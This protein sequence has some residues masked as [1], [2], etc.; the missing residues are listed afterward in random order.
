MK[1]VLLKLST[2]TWKKQLTSAGWRDLRPLMW[3]LLSGLLLQKNDAESLRKDSKC[4]IMI[5]SQQGWPELW[6]NRGLQNEILKC[7]LEAI[8]DSNMCRAI[9]QA[10]GKIL[11]KLCIY[12]S[13]VSL[14][15]FLLRF[16]IHFSYFIFSLFLSFFFLFF[17]TFV[18]SSYFYIYFY[19]FNLF[20]LLL[21][22]F[23][24]LL[25]FSFLSLHLTFNLDY[26]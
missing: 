10:N 22:S 13:C 7:F 1:S 5:A 4:M 26:Y 2:R 23:V 14:F 3:L 19:S 12:T 9:L 8:T 18:F 20:L 25:L 21:F 17:F 15:G 16:F 24:P 6:L 11:D